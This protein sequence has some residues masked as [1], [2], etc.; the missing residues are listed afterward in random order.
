MCRAGQAAG[1]VDRRGG[2]LR[3]RA[4]SSP[5]RASLHRRRAASRGRS[6]G[7]A[8]PRGDPRWCQRPV[9]SDP[10]S[11]GRR[12]QHLRASERPEDIQCREVRAIAA[13]VP[14]E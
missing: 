12:F 3:R 2:V 7:P 9:R 5:R 13:F 1:R 10:V 4:R 14:R 6:S 11:H 8:R